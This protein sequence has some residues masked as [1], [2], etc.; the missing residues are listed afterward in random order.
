MI[1]AYM[2]GPMADCTPEEMTDWREALKVDFSEIKWLDPCA[3]SYKPQQWRQLVEDDIADIDASDFVL[4]YYWKAGTGTSMELAYAHYIAKIPTIVVVPDFKSVSPW[5]RY[6][7]DYLV[8][9]FEHA[10]KIIKDDGQRV[11]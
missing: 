2:G 6:H 11:L 4:A 10:M 7:A 1:T 3:R 5:V 8:E 9:S